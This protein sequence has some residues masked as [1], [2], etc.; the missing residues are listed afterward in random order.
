MTFATWSLNKELLPSTIQVL[1]MILL[2]SF[3]QS[4]QVICAGV[5]KIYWYCPFSR[6]SAPIK[7]FLKKLINFARNFGSTWLKKKKMLCIPLKKVPHLRECAHSCL[8]CLL[9]LCI[10]WANTFNTFHAYNEYNVYCVNACSTSMHTVR[11]I[12]CNVTQCECIRE[13]P[14][15]C[16]LCLA[17]D[18]FG[19]VGKNY[20][21]FFFIFLSKKCFA[22]LR[23]PLK[24]E[25]GDFECVWTHLH[26]GECP[27]PAS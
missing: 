12:S 1:A 21:I 13:C 15:S 4:A 27:A 18:F 9:S 24:S 5:R 17:A 7:V 10:Y 26:C 25:K 11:V 3:W 20:F 22:M 16:L 19:W 14:A 2:F 6:N 8:P 23:L